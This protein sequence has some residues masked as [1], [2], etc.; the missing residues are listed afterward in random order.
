LR[1]N[2][3]VTRDAPN[4]SLSM[5]SAVSTRTMRRCGVLTTTSRCGG[6][7]D[8]ADE[9]IGGVAMRILVSLSMSAWRS[10]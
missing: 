8:G 4:L 7:Q 5:V 1:L 3:P 10:V 6:E 2:R 9:A